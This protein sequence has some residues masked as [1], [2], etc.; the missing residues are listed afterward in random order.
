MADDYL[1]DAV[2]DHW[3]MILAAY[4]MHEEH[5]PVVLYD[6]QEQRIYVYPYQ[7]FKDD[8]N[9]RNQAQLADQYEKAL[10][11][12]KIVVFVRDNVERKLASFSVDQ[13]PLG[14]VDDG[15]SKGRIAKS[16][17]VADQPG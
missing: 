17:S 11:T 5:K 7:G 16:R 10:V 4:S 12:N 2:E 14:Q 15:N 1:W 8:L 6:I 13:E 3:E 9:A